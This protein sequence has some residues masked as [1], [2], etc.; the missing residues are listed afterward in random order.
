MINYKLNF[1]SI[2]LIPYFSPMFLFYQD[3]YANAFLHDDNMNFRVNLHKMV[4]MTLVSCF[5]LRGNFLCVGRIG[6]DE[7]DPV[8]NHC[9]W[10]VLQKGPCLTTVQQTQ[11]S[12]GDSVCGVGLFLSW[13]RRE[14]HCHIPRAVISECVGDAGSTRPTPFF[15]IM[16]C[17]LCL[18]KT[19]YY[20]VYSS[21][22]QEW[23][24]GGVGKQNMKDLRNFLKLV[25][26]FKFPYRDFYLK[27]TFFCSCHFCCL[28]RVTL[29]FFS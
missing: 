25:D 13:E 23:G 8:W 3:Q 1:L 16:Q 2:A 5:F 22:Q 11:A 19:R 9:G 15:F 29:S 14:G 18:V 4:G 12:S 6:E 17:N 20:F 28:Y 21:E 24:Q 7:T 27:L 10:N 26:I